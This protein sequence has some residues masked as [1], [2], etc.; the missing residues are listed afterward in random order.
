MFTI[1]RKILGL[2][3]LSIAVASTGCGGG[4]SAETSP[5]SSP[6]WVGE[7]INS[8]AQ[9]SSSSLRINA[10][11]SG[12]LATSRAIARAGAT[13]LLDLLFLVAEPEAGPR[14]AR[15]QQYIHD[16]GDL[17][18]PD[19]HV[20]VADEVFLQ[21]TTPTALAQH[22][23]TLQSAIALVRQ[24]LPHARV[25]VTVSPYATLNRPDM[26]PLTKCAASLALQGEEG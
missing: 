16:N 10:A 5:S 7:V 21:A 26:A 13:N 8:P 14:L 19:V 15:L 22:W 24:H 17:L 9:L 12:D 3:V 23:A 20:L 18:T 6:R 1:F 11:Y 2:A 4:E 25:G